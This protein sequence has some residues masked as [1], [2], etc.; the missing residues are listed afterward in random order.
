MHLD[1]FNCDKVGPRIS[2]ARIAQ[3]ARLGDGEMAAQ[4]V[5]RIKNIRINALYG[6]K[7]HYNAAD[8]R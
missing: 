7:K 3:L 6:K 1:K 5:D 4:L 2:S 8:R